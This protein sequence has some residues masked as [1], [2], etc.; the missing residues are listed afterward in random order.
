MLQIITMLASNLPNYLINTIV[1]TNVNGLR[2]KFLYTFNIKGNNV[3]IAS[4][5]IGIKLT[6]KLHFECHEI[7][8]K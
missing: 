2:N 4:N 3:Y 6:F 7:R 1:G 8:I 5:F